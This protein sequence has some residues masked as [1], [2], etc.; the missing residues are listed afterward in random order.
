MGNTIAA[1]EQAYK[2]G[3]FYVIQRQEALK[4]SLINKHWAHVGLPVNTRNVTT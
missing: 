3:D 1:T 4:T 2:T